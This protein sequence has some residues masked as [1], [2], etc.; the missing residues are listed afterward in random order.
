MI[1]ILG[2][3]AFYHDSSASII[4]DGEIKIAVQEERFTRIKHDNNF[5]I[6]SIEYI[7]ETEKIKLDDI[8]KIVFYEKPFLKYERLIETYLAFLPRGLKSYLSSMPIWIKEKLFQKKIIFDQLKKID[9]K[10]NKKEK[11][12]FSEHHTSHAASAFFPSPF[13]DA[14]VIIMDGVGEWN[15]TTIFTGVSNKLLKKDHIDFPHSIGLLYSAFTYYLGFKVNSGEYKVMGLAPYGKPVYSKLIKDYLVD[16]KDDGS[17][18]LNM[19]YFDYATALTMTNKKF[20]NIFGKPKRMSE[21]SLDQ[22]HFDI[23]ASIQNVTEEII[24][25]IAKFFKEKYKS[26]NLCLAGGVALNCVANGILNKLNIF[27]NIWVQPASGDAGCSLGAALNY[28][29]QGLN[30]KR[31]INDFDSMKGSYLGPK[32]DEN[33]IKLSLNKLS[34]NYTY[35]ENQDELNKNVAKLLLDNK[36]V[37]WFQGR[38]EFGPRALGNR[39]ILANPL[40]SDM[41]KKLNLKIKFRESFRPF[42]PSVLFDE[43]QNWFDIQCK[44]PYM[45]FVAN[46]IDGKINKDLKIRSKGVDQINEIRSKIPSVTHV[47]NSARIQSVHKETNKV[48]Y[49]LIYEFFKLSKCPIL[50]NTSFNIRGEPIVNSINDAY[51]CFMGTEMDYLICG[52]FL[53]EKNNQNKTLKKDY[54]KEFK[55]D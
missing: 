3:S 44:S 25:K 21:S 36:V 48:F 4:C 53:L 2:L 24:I 20:E 28:W 33:Q 1:R 30:K 43:M 55:L 32:F 11:I 10:F 29:Y 51:K 37:G 26:N 17:F 45:S 52:K 15:T 42:A 27:Q 23:A 41:Q 54:R 34:A 14:L 9:P 6:K 40:S 13:S 19:K 49:D 16:I 50:V 7:L 22:F 31:I 47:D 38:M 39:S 35:Y 12:I 5:P 46:I 18:R 8:D